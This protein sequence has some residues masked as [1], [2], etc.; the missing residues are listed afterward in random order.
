MDA[1]LS[2]MAIIF[3]YFFVFCVSTAAGGG[4]I[5]GLM[6]FVI[7]PVFT[8]KMLTYFQCCVTMACLNLLAA[9]FKGGSSD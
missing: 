1:L 6:K 4:I 2:C 5:Y 7:V 8:V 3:L 9:L